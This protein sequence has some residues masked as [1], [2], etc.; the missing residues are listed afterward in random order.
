MFSSEDIAADESAEIEYTKAFRTTFYKNWMHE[1]FSI[2]SL[3][4]R[5]MIN[6][7]SFVNIQN[8]MCFL[9][10]LKLYLSLRINKISALFVYLFIYNNL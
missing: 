6:K 2:N 3:G 10:M 8:N 9:V 4:S 1:R 5:F 7:Q